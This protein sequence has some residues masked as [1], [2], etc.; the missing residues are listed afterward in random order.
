MSDDII[1]PFTVDGR[2]YR[3][4]RSLSADQQC[5]VSDS[6][7]R[8]WQ[9]MPASARCDSLNLLPE[10]DYPEIRLGGVSGSGE[11]CASWWLGCNATQAGSGPGLFVIE[12]RIWPGIFDIESFCGTEFAG[13]L[14]YILSNPM[15]R[16]DGARVQ[17]SSAR[18]GFDSSEC[19]SFPLFESTHEQ[20]L[21]DARVCCESTT[22]DNG[23]VDISVTRP[24][25]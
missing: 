3:D 15:V 17:V 7:L 23:I 18:Y 12:T 10:G 24:A 20:M 19:D 13:F 4:C 5:G 8:S 9:N 1:Q 25:G 11:V 16:S 21:A 22:D 2:T 14:D 6:L